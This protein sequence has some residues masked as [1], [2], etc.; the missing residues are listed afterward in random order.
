VVKAMRA[1]HALDIQPWDLSPALRERLLKE[2]S[3]TLW[4]LCACANEFG[5]S[6]QDLADIN[7]DK[8]EER[9]LNGDLYQ[10]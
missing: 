1:K 9:R 10:T 5:I 4:A 8:L 2:L 3:D 7:F 6:L